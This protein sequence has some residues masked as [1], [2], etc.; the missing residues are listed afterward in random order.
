MVMV[1]KVV[2]NQYITKK[3]PR[4]VDPKL[5]Q[6]QAQYQLMHGKR[7]SEGRLVEMAVDEVLAHG[8][9]TRKGD[10]RGVLAITGMFKGRKGTNA[11]KDLD[12]VVYGV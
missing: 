2:K 8:V 6:L 10:G 11:A 12:K 7:I 3:M 4:S 5:K 9:L 1:V